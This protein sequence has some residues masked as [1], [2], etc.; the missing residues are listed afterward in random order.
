[1]SSSTTRERS[2]PSRNR[3]PHRDYD[4]IERRVGD[5]VWVVTIATFAV[6]FGAAV[7]GNWQ[8]SQNVDPMYAYDILLRTLRYGGTYYQNGIHNKGPLEIFTFQAASWITSRDGFWY[9]I[10]FFIAVGATVIGFAAA[11]T[12]QAFKGSR[13]IAIAA[14]A[15]VFVHL[16]LGPSDYAGVLYARNMTTPMLATAWIIALWD[17]AWTSR[18]TRP[19]CRDRLRCAAGHRGPELS[20]PRPSPRRRSRSCRSRSCGSAARR[21]ITGSSTPRSSRQGRSRS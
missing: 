12:A 14:A 2:N 20:P 10:S 15:V 7:I 21:P 18:R 13:E 6:V 4:Q 19:R 17:R 1:M 11:R 9:G 5:A 16:T 8:R 3:N